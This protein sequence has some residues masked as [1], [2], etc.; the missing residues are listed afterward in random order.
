MATRVPCHRVAN[1]IHVANNDLSHPKLPHRRAMVLPSPQPFAVHVDL[2]SGD[3]WPQSSVVACG[4][5]VLGIASHAIAHWL[6]AAP[7]FLGLVPTAI[8]AWYIP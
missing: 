2:V 4:K 7:P 3:D 6:G 1:C 8:S 5:I